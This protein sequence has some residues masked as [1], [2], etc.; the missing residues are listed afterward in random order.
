MA[1]ILILY[2]PVLIAAYAVY[3]LA[4]RAKQRSLRFLQGPPSP[5]ILLGHEHDLLHQNVVGDLEFKWF[6]DYGT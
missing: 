2:L 4:V 6:K 1:V 3:V 5:S